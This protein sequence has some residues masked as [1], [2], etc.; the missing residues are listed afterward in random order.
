VIDAGGGRRAMAGELFASEASRK[1]LAGIVIDGACRDTA[2]LATMALPVYARSATPMAG[3]V[4]R[5]AET[6]TPIQ[7]GGVTVRPGD[8]LIG[9]RDG[10]VVA[11]ED[12]LEGLLAR[13]EAVQE[14]EGL[15]L[16][17]IERGESLFDLLELAEHLDALRQGQPSKL[18]FKL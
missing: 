15:V 7:C 6:G 2:K 3:T 1:G 11:A 12:E 18:R 9:D 17:R 5:L 8:W 16:Q 14:A 10:I 13:A 4:E